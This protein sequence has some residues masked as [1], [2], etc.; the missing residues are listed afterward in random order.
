MCRIDRNTRLRQS[1]RNSEVATRAY[2]DLNQ[3]VLAKVPGFGHPKLC[4]WKT[5][6]GRFRGQSHTHIH[7][8]RNREKDKNDVP[9]RL[10]VGVG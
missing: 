2:S 7:E 1:L 6:S 10:K 5:P 3:E 4:L 8:G 9:K